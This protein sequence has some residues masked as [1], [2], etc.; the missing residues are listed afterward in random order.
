MSTCQRRA[1]DNVEDV[2]SFLEWKKDCCPALAARQLF[3]LERRAPACPT[4]GAK[5]KV[6]TTFEYSTLP[7]G[8]SCHSTFTCDFNQWPNVCGNA[9][10]AINERGRTSILTYVNQQVSGT[11]EKHDVSLFANGKYGFSGR[12]GPKAKSV[13]EMKLQNGEN[14]A[15]DGWGLIGCQIE[16]YPFGS[17]D[18]QRGFPRNDIVNSRAVN[19][20]IPAKENGN[21][22]NALSN[23][24]A[25]AG[26]AAGGSGTT[27]SMWAHGLV[28]CEFSYNG[29]LAQ[30]I[31]DMVLTACR[32][33]IFE[34]PGRPR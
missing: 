8:A 33:G 23:F 22:G 9:K 34:C 16:E 30:S 17:G 24:Y 14:P 15:R 12:V 28:Y 26:R 6:P 31:I 2:Q 32:Y 3:G 27:A 19:R 29:S 18:P 20:L 4:P 1:E 5:P 25:A 13:A 10:S 11:N 7:A 21:H